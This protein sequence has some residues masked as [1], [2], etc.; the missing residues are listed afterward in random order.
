MCAEKA[1]KDVAGERGRGAGETDKE[2]NS[3]EGLWM[4]SFNASARSAEACEDSS[5]RRLELGVLSLLS[6]TGA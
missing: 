4:S 6:T 1:E 3:T 2:K 5:V